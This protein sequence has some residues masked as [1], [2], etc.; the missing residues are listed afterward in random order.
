MRKRIAELEEELRSANYLLGEAAIGA[1]ETASEIERLEAENTELREALCYLERESYDLRCVD[2]PTG[3]DDYDIAW[4]VVSHHMN[5]PR[6]R[7]V[8]ER[9]KTPLEAIRAAINQPKEE[10]K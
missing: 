4:V 9:C 5:K 3:G 6:E 10:G 8:A 1:R 7:E 2:V